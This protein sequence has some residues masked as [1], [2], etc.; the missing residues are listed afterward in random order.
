MAANRELELAKALVW[1]LELLEAHPTSHDEGYVE[2]LE[3]FQ[4]DARKL[5]KPYR[6]K[7]NAANNP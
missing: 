5:L 3:D 2:E 6:R 4:E 7:L 1:A